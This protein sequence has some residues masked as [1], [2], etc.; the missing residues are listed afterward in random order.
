MIEIIDNFHWGKEKKV[1][2]FDKHNIPGLRNFAYWNLGRA[3]PSIPPHYHS[4]IIEFHCLVKGKRDCTVNKKSYSITGNELFITFPYEE[5]S[6]GSHFQTPCEFYAFQIYL[7]KTEN[8]LGLDDNFSNHLLELLT[9]IK[10]RHLVVNNTAIHNIKMAFNLFAQDTTIS[11]YHGV[12]YLCCFLF[13]VKNLKPIATKK[14]T[15]INPCIKKSIDYID[16]HIKDHFHLSDVS[17]ISG[18]S[19]TQFKINFKKE[20]G[21]TPAEYISFKKIE[22]AKELLILTNKPVTEIAMDTGFSTSNYF[23]SVFKKYTTFSPN[24]YR[25]QFGLTQ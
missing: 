7:D 11:I 16:Q 18:Y 10:E 22:Y 14:S 2:T 17:D 20:T 1:L 12:Q 4:E 21:I 19:I 3:I 15:N 5:H 25:K 8:L 13:N 24:N 23:S 6:I 9:D